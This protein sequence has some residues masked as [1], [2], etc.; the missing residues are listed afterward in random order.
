MVKTERVIVHN[1]NP[2]ILPKKFINSEGIEYI[3]KTLSERMLESLLPF[4]LKYITDYERLIR[5]N[6]IQCATTNHE[7][8]LVPIPAI[9]N[10]MPAGY[11]I[12]TADW[13]QDGR[14]VDFD[15]IEY[16]KSIYPNIENL[17]YSRQIKTLKYMA[18]PMCLGLSI[19]K[20][21]K[22]EFLEGPDRLGTILIN[23]DLAEKCSVELRQNGYKRVPLLEGMKVRGP[24]IKGTLKYSE[25]VKGICFLE[26]SWKKIPEGP[27]EAIALGWWIE[28]TPELLC[29]NSVSVSYTVWEHITESLP[30]SKK[31]EL[32]MRFDKMNRQELISALLFENPRN[33]SLQTLNIIEAIREGV[34]VNYDSVNRYIK[35]RISDILDKEVFNPIL[36]GIRAIGIECSTSNKEIIIPVKYS[37]A[38]K[39][40]EKVV[41][42]RDPCSSKHSLQIVEIGGYT[43]SDVIEVPRRCAIAGK[44]DFDGDQ[45]NIVSLNIFN[46]TFSIDLKNIL[47]N[48]KPPI[49]IKTEK[50]P[51]ECGNDRNKL[52]TYATS[53]ELGKQSTGMLVHIRD[54]MIARFRADEQLVELGFD[55]GAQNSLQSKNNTRSNITNTMDYA[56][57]EVRS[58][59]DILNL[60]LRSLIRRNSTLTMLRK[61][62]LYGKYAPEY[63]SFCYNTLSKY[64]NRYVRALNTSLITETLIEEKRIPENHIASAK[65]IV[66][67]TKD[68]EDIEKRIS[69]M[70]IESQKW[71]LH[72]YALVCSLLDMPFG[73]GKNILL[74]EKVL[75]KIKVIQETTKPITFTISKGGTNVKDK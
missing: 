6:Y 67:K 52:Y 75:D 74:A 64:T 61:G 7:D 48:T 72:S 41:L 59:S 42:W 34:P 36:S 18:G 14:L 68:E 60:D 30:T 28:S 35:S 22:I 8:E 3:G 66:Y 65:R 62:V 69:L 15:T 23:P 47:N 44:G 25:E 38:F 70:I 43:N 11:F 16:A 27:A 19:A 31:A 13:L 12:A 32:L 45:Y 26:G 24:F 5:K 33:G 37:N 58:I 9:F 2:K 57:N 54:N 53:I 63:G 21:A 10:T 1:G 4:D 73:F 17:D 40:G 51:V 46:K 39:L 49:K 29:K 55:L 50:Q 71:H 56:L 20:D